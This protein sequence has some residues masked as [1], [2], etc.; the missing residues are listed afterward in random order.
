MKL[1][2]WDRIYSFVFLATMLAVVGYSVVLFVPLI[3]GFNSVDGDYKKTLLA[4]G[5]TLVVVFSLLPVAITGFMLLVVPK[6]GPPERSGKINIWFSTI[7][8]YLFVLATIWSLGILFV[9]T[10]VMMTAASVGSLV[11]RKGSGRGSVGSEAGSKSGRGG[12]KR[13]RNR[14]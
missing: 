4:D 2:R 10:L 3:Q 11:G 7:L 13:R 12:G 14:G 1:P 6:Y 8:I 5:N 9:P